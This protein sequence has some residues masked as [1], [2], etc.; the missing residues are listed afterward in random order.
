MSIES[1]EYDNVL[2]NAKIDV[3]PRAKDVAGFM[4]DQ[5]DKLAIAGVLTGVSA[6]TVANPAKAEEI[7]RT[8][9]A[10][11]NNSSHE[12]I[13]ITVGAA[14]GLTFGVKE[15]IKAKRSNS[16]IEGNEWAPI[17]GNTVT[18]AIAGYFG[19][20][21]FIEGK[22]AIDSE[23]WGKVKDLIA[24]PTAYISAKM[25]L[26]FKDIGNYI[27]SKGEGLVAQSEEHLGEQQ[28]SHYLRN[29]KSSNLNE[30][31]D[32]ILK[33]KQM[34]YKRNSRGFYTE[35]GDTQT[36]VKLDERGNLYTESRIIS[37]VTGLGKIVRRIKS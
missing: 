15:Y 33:L 7:T 5:K 2:G 25:L 1:L 8:I 35:D 4:W 34:G 3:A 9:S 21:F 22:N 14:T 37:N 12:G 31:D 19:S 27:K 17:V 26:K 13:K 28:L 36:Y 30:H 20:H 16:K 24:L 11:T 23:N 29:S 32:A 6:L 10:V 18:G